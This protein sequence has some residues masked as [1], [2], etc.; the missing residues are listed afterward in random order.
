M[1]AQSQQR[2]V[3]FGNG[4][5]GQRYVMTPAAASIDMR[6]TVVG[7]ERIHLETPEESVSVNPVF[8]QRNQ[9]YISEPM[10]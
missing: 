8:L 5:V 10:A 9:E 7:A 6:Y 1:S 3:V 2:E 4:M